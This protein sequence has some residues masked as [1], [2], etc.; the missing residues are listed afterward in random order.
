MGPATCL[1]NKGWHTMEPTPRPVLV[2]MHNAH[3]PPGYLETALT[4]LHRWGWGKRPGCTLK[5]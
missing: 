1:L 5:T 4:A 2:F 3:V